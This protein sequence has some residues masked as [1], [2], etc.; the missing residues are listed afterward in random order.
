[1]GGHFHDLADSRLV[2]LCPT[3]FFLA[4][5]RLRSAISSER[6]RPAGRDHDRLPG[7]TASSSEPP[8]KGRLL[9]LPDVLLA[10]VCSFVPGRDL[11]RFGL[12][13]TALLA[14]PHTWPP[15]LKLARPTRRKWEFDRL[16]VEE[17]ERHLQALTRLASRAV[18]A[19]RCLWVDE[20]KLADLFL[21]KL[22]GPLLQL[23]A[24]H[25]ELADDGHGSR[26]VGRSKG[27]VLDMLAAEWLP[28]LR[29][30]HLHSKLSQRTC[31]SLCRVLGE[32]A[33]PNL[34]TI[35]ID[36][37][38]WEGVAALASALKTRPA[39][40]ADLK[41]ICVRVA[42]EF[43]FEQVDSAWLMGCVTEGCRALW[44]SLPTGS[45]R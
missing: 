22:Q 24:L 27:V 29:E 16:P 34:E 39:K 45:L 41:A 13:C 23:T 28:E 43:I 8:S 12:S 20:A 7:P 42:Y 4:F 38:R 1:M 37:C 5:R 40:C 6:K 35:S 31:S 33:C 44:E 21:S 25:V 9:S 18:N 10:Q 19:V 2:P 17:R 11:A 30:L 14:S 3:L 32:G 15:T 36:N 26:G